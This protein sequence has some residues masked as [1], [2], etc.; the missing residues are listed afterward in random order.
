MHKIN[1]YSRIKKRSAILLPLFLLF[2]TVKICPAQGDTLKTHAVNDTV[3]LKKEAVLHSPRKAALYSTMLPG[4]GQVYNKKYWKVPVLY[5]GIAGLTYAI[6]STNNNYLNYRS[7]YRIR[8]DTIAST[9]DPYA[10]KT[11]KTYL[12]TDE[13]LNTTKYFHR[14]RDLSIFGAALLY[15]LNIVDATVD[16]HLFTFD[17]SD[18]LSLHVQPTWINTAGINNTRNSITGLSL[19]LNF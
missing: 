16:A 17:V 18:D 5:A 4:L 3:I 7:A 8:M 14:W 19:H 1:K 12:S 11:S 15:V 13:L 9:V 2:I 10:D 6:I